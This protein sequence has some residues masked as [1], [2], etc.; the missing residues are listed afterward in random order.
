MPSDDMFGVIL[1]P[2]NARRSGFR[3][4]VN[5]N[6]VRNDLLFQ[7]VSQQNTDWQGIWDAVSSINEDGWVAEIEIPFKTL[8]FDPANDTWGINFMR[9]TPRKNEWIGWVSRNNTMNPSIAGVA[10]GFENM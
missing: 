4:N 7:N 5:A 8:S 3:F 2:F 10:T 1:D 6:G 9:W